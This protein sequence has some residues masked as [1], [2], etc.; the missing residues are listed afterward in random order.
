M[1]RSQLFEEIFWVLPANRS[2]FTAKALVLL[3]CYSI[4][5]VMKYYRIN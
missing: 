3:E 4:F 1:P 2:F 5:P